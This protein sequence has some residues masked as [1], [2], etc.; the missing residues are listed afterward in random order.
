MAAVED[1]PLFQEAPNGGVVAEDA[2]HCSSPVSQL[3]LEFVRVRLGGL[4]SH[5]W[6]SECTCAWAC[7]CVCVVVLWCW[8]VLVGWLVSYAIDLYSELVEW[9]ALKKDAE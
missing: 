4:C 1:M 9:I 8:L 6:V 3:L 2:V 5:W 7:G